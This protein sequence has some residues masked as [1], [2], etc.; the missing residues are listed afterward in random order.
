MDVANLISRVRDHYV[1]QFQ[2]FIAQQ[3]EDGARGAA[4]VKFQ[5]EDGSSLFENMYCA[6]FVRNEGQAQV[7]ELI[8]EQV[9]SFTRIRCSF[10][11]TA[12]TIDHLR[13]DDVLLHHD[14]EQLPAEGLSGWFRRWFDPAEERYDEAAEFSK[15]V[16]SLTISTKS[17][18]ADLGTAEPDAF[19]DM[20]QLLADA[21]A[22]Q[23]RVT[24]S[25]DEDQTEQ[26]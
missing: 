20:L 11:Q 15:I 18:S 26:S 4:E 24:A 19:W 7:I 2:A 12:P 23:I 13:W 6:D 3:R 1:E 8:P 17:I 22:T 5:L 14:A 21:G 10:G 9:L 16:H 25:R